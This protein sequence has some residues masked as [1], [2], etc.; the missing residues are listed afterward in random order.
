MKFTKKIQKAIDFAAIKHV[1]QAR[2]AGGQPY[3]V[4]PFSVAWI[5]AEYV[6][7]EE[8]V[9]AGLLHDIL[10]DV[11][12]SSFVEIE[13]EFGMEVARMVKDISEDKDPSAPP[14]VN[15][16]WQERKEKYLEHL[17]LTRVEAIY[18]SAADKI[19]NLMS[20]Q[21]QYQI[22]GAD[23]WKKFSANREKSFWF[24]EE[25]M[26]IVKERIPEHPLAIIYEKT[27]NEFKKFV[28]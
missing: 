23:M 20:L 16:P 15:P 1:H 27:F 10:E 6:S 22:V 5:L 19:H 17:R 2:K 11:P 7:D 4:H 18:V 12:G 24:Y 3:I 14:G 26:K 21:A 13:K 9:V 8:V 25:V 28:F